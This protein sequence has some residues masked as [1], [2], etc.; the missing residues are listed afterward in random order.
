MLACLLNATAVS[1]DVELEL[2][3]SPAIGYF[4]FAGS[5]LPLEEQGCGCGWSRFETG[6]SAAVERDLCDDWSCC[7]GFWGTR[8]A[9]EVLFVLAV[10]AV[11]CYYALIWRSRHE[12]VFSPIF[13]DAAAI[14][15]ELLLIIIIVVAC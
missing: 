7:C 9:C 6:G 8:G 5:P 2:P 13:V 3:L 11:V 14:F 1:R 4:C 15:V 10:V 12:T